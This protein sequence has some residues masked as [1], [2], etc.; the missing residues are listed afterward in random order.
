MSQK[1]FASYG[2]MET[3]VTE[4]ADKCGPYTEI[5]YNDWLQ[6]TPYQQEH[7][8]W[9]VTDVPGADG[10]ISID[11]MTKLWENP[12][13]SQ[14][15]AEGATINL[16]SSDFDLILWCV[17]VGTGTTAVV[18]TVSGKT[19][20]A[21]LVAATSIGAMYRTITK[22][23]DTTYTVSQAYA[24]GTARNEYLIPYQ[25]YGIKLTAT[26]K[27][28]AIAMDV[29]TSADKCMLSDGETS[30][31]DAL[32]NIGAYYEAEIPAGTDTSISAYLTL[33]AGK[34]IVVGTTGTTSAVVTSFFGIHNE[35][36]SI[37]YAKAM[38]TGWI[39]NLTAI[40]EL[41]KS[42]KIYFDY[43]GGNSTTTK[44]KGKL[45]AIRIK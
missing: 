16:S 6:L 21:Y 31:E 43:L 41:A 20:G 13:P 40:V 17:R 33:P 38:Y 14:A 36:A 22:T 37:F 9:D 32:D 30:V 2:D 4:I 3:L 29:S 45:S 11:L 23:N 28:N 25:V 10:T 1:N 42:E 5:S 24:G 7:G 12:D 27:I 26:V 34:Y 35:D 8:R 18:S 19:G 15:M 39:Y 44:T